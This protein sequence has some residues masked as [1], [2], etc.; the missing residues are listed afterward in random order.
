MALVTK[1][2]LKMRKQAEMAKKIKAHG[3]LPRKAKLLTRKNLC[4]LESTGET[5]EDIQRE[6]EA[7]GGAQALKGKLSL[8]RG[9]IIVAELVFQWRLAN[10]DVANREE[11]ILNM[12]NAVVDSRKPLDAILVF[13]VGDKFY[14]MDGHHRLAAYDTARWIGSIP[15]TAFRGTLEEA[16][17]EALR[18]NSRNK[19]PM[20]KGDKQEAAWRLVKL[21]LSRAQI[22]Q[23]TTVSTSNISTMKAKLTKLKDRGR[24]TD[25]LAAVTWA[26]ARRDWEPEDRE[27]D[28]DGWKERKANKIVAALLKANIA[29]M[30]REQPEITAIALERLDANLVARLMYE[31][32]LWPENEDFIL[33]FIEDRLGEEAAGAWRALSGPQ[34]F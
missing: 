24:T 13:P 27:F 18:L 9:S 11:H 2:R 15:A 33:G 29:F 28:V 23:W 31:W 8:S 12:A 26:Q 1:G 17:L 30:L 21:G 7:T 19:L 32:F 6:L 25:E 16:Y 14:A 4:K 34:K 5:H 3:T 10:E 22:N 20:T